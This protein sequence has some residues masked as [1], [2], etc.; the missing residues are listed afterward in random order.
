[1]LLLNHFTFL[2]FSCFCLCMYLFSLRATICNKIIVIVNQFRVIPSALHNHYADDVTFSN[3]S[4][5][6]SP[7]SPSITQ[8]LFYSWLKAHL[9]INLFHHSLL[10]PTGLPSR[11]ILDRTYSA[12]HCY[13]YFFIYFCFLIFWSC[14]RLRWLNQLS[15][16][17]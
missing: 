3:S 12:Q 6:C 17:R 9:S 1:M 15:S 7:L 8:S 14:G 16:A 5:T 4:S 2:C 11:T 13:F 10:A